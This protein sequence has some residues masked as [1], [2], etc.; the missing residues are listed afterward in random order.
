MN[1]NL[2]SNSLLKK[3]KSM[4]ERTE[5][6]DDLKKGWGTQRKWN[7]RKYVPQFSIDDSSPLRF[8]V[9]VLTSIY[10]LH[11]VVKQL[12]SEATNV[13]S[14]IR[15]EVLWS[16]LCTYTVC[17][18][19]YLLHVASVQQGGQQQKKFVGRALPGTNFFFHPGPIA[20]CQRAIGRARKKHFV[21]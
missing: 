3:K 13:R 20:C 17:F 4:T 12:S 16:N 19:P 9:Q 21:G 2:S 5:E 6:K 8:L 11:S 18:Q 1:H 15:L 10:R 7:L 14:F